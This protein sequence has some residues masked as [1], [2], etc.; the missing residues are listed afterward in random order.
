[1]TDTD[2]STTDT[3]A[4][5]LSAGDE[6]PYHYRGYRLS[7]S[8]DGDVWW[9]AYNGTDRLHLEPV[10]DEFLDDFL[11]MKRNGGAIRITEAGDVIT[12]VEEGDGSDDYRTVYVGQLEFDGTL[13]PSDDPEHTVDVNPD[14]LDPGDLWK[15]VYDGARYSFAGDRFWWEDSSTKLRHDFAEPLPAEITRELRRLRVNGGRFVVTPNG[16][17]VTQI[18]TVKTPD[19]VR[20]QFRDLP[21]PVKRFLQLRRDRGGVDMVPVYV[22]SLDEEQLPIGVEEPTRLTDPLSEQEAASLE[23]WVSAMGSYE[24]DDLSRDDHRFDDGGGG[25]R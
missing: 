19:D 22:G 10:P 23:A 11:Q 1:M 14:G 16:D 13:V 12:K 17:V 3:S 20:A 24:E 18:P 25:S 4:Q 2:R 9:Q 7:V 5:T 6:W 15:S 8:A 21:R